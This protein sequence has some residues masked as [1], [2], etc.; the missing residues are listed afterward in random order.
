MPAESKIGGGT[1]RQHAST[2]LTAGFRHLLHDF[3]RFIVRRVVRKD[4]FDIRII[5]RKR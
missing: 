5:L 1:R 4:E 2:S 3:I